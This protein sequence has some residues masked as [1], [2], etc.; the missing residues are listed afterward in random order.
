MTNSVSYTPDAGAGDSRPSA[1]QN[2][3]L[4][5]LGTKRDVAALCRMSLRWVDGQIAKG[6]PVIKL[7][8]RRCRFD[9]RE[10]A[11]WLRERYHV[12]RRGPPR[13]KTQP[14]QEGA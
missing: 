3:A 12:Q 13:V 1:K 5:Q 8:S 4:P 11:A 9:L 7:S 2:D 14:E 6:M 10:V